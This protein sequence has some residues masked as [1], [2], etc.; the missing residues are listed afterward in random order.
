M[1]V[2]NDFRG[3]VVRFTEERQKHLAEFGCE[4]SNLQL[5]KQALANPDVM[6]E[7]F[8]H[9]RLRLFYRIYTR[10]IEHRNFHVVV[11][12]R[13]YDMLVVT[14]FFGKGLAWG[15]RTWEA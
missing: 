14:A 12:V 7:A 4:G 2:L 9:P 6:T 3:R 1:I 15:T 5:I 10:R 11:K 13:G 8:H